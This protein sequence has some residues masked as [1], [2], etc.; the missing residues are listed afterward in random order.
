MEQDVAGLEV[1]FVAAGG[2]VDGQ[3]VAAALALG[4]SSGDAFDGG[5]DGV[6]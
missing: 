5:A 6:M 4:E 3:G 1:D 2:L